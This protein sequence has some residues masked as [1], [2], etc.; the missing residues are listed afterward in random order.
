[1]NKGAA[2]VSLREG[3][4]DTPLPA[5]ARTGQ[6]PLRLRLSKNRFA[7]YGINADHKGCAFVSIISPPASA[8][9]PA[10]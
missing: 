8:Y 3:G 4:G 6:K 9:T 5:A 2:F 7:H 1:M 10:D